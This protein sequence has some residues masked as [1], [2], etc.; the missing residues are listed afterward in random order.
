[1]LIDFN[2]RL[3]DINKFKFIAAP[4]SDQISLEIDKIRTDL[5]NL[6]LCGFHTFYCPIRHNENFSVTY[7]CKK[8][9]HA[10]KIYANAIPKG[11]GKISVRFIPKLYLSQDAPF[12][13][14]ISSL[15]IKGTNYILLE[16]PFTIHQN[17]VPEALNKILYNCNLSPIFSDFHMALKLYPFSEIEKMIRIKNA[18]FQFNIKSLP[19][20]D[21]I[22]IIRKIT[23]NGNI[24]LFGTNCDHFSLN[25]KEMSNIIEV[26]R[27]KISDT[28]YRNIVIS[29]KKQ[30]I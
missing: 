15:T 29:A 19:D 12:I 17:Y 6:A 11:C 22:K 5:S 9:A 27:S 13:K 20:P 4:T 2:C 25:I 16:L 23:S 26:F 1:M 7:T 28:T 14:N 8:I 21:V 3:F 10:K 24:V 18:M 30:F